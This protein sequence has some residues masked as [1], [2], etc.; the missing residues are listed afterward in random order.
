[1]YFFVDNVKRRE[2]IYAPI[3]ASH[4]FSYKLND[5]NFSFLGNSTM[6]AIDIDTVVYLRYLPSD[7][8][9]QDIASWFQYYSV[10]YVSL[11]KN[12]NC[13]Y[14]GFRDYKYVLPSVS[15]LLVIT[16]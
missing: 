8:S 14:I 1:M 6:A 12:S 3:H 2:Y 5:H 13:C 16:P 4:V 9:L 11:A 15:I 10:N 7:A